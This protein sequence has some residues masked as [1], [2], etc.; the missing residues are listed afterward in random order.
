MDNDGFGLCPQCGA[1]LKLDRSIAESDG[2]PFEPCPC[3]KACG[4]IGGHQIYMGHG[5]FESEMCKECGGSG[6]AIGQEGYWIPGLRE[7]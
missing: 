4:G 5:N 7:P 2:V 6:V 3:C 1:R